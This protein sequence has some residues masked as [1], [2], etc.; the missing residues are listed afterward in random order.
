MGQLSKAQTWN[1]LVHLIFWV[2][3]EVLILFFAY[4]VVPRQEVAIAASFVYLLGLMLLVYGHLWWLVPRY[5][6]HQKWLPYAIG[7]VGLILL[8]AAFR[9]FLGWSVVSAMNWG[10]EE[11]FT[12]TFFGSMFVGGFF[13]VFISIPL[14]LVDGW[15]KRIELE[16]ELK[17]QKLEA[18]LRFLKAQVNPHFLF[19]ALN[20]IYALSFIQSEKAPEMILKLSDMMSYMLYDCKHE[21]VPLSAEIAYLQ[22]YIELQQLKKEGEL[23]VAFNVEALPHDP[24]I[25]PMLLIPFFENAFKHG[26]LEDVQRGWAK[27]SLAIREQA[28]HFSIQNSIGPHTSPS[29]KG[30]V[31]LANIQA[32]LDLLYQGQHQLQISQEQGV[33]SVSLRL[34]LEPTDISSVSATSP[35]R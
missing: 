20:N 35:S 33:F 25:K 2:C 18:E 7:L 26:N 21:E 28:L 1:I 23:K 9:F 8:S 24:L 27:A 3:L 29:E 15:F 5:W 31:G 14:R 10:L 22:N 13:V 34:P 32:R 17:T 12:P 11:R 30:G 16:Q 6:D 4:G 19:N